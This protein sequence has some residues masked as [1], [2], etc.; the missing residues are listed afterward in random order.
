MRRFWPVAFMLVLPAHAGEPMSAA[1]FDAY[2][3]GK[4]LSYAVGGEIYGAE[5]YLPH[6][7]VIWA[8]RGQECAEGSWYEAGG[9][10]CFVYEH[11]STPQC[12]TFFREE[13]G[14]RAQFQGDPDA[15]ELSEVAQ[16]RNPLVCA[17]PD[18]GV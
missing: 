12:W 14:L 18:V 1:E 10:I 11:D 7:R 8:F 16:S 9:Q 2:S 13:D 17:G 15:T 5:Q 3:V 6:R 4:T